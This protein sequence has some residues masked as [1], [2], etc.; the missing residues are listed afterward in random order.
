MRFFGGY[1]YHSD[2]RMTTPTRPMRSQRFLR[3]LVALALHHTPDGPAI[4]RQLDLVGHADRD[5]GLVETGDRPVDPAA[6]HHAVTALDGG[7][8]CLAVLPL[9]L[10]RADE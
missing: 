10:L 9:L 5:G 7:E 3:I 1:R 2:T 8:E 6:R 4:E